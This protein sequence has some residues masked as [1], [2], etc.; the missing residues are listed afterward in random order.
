MDLNSLQLFVHV[1]QQG[2][3]SAASRKVRTPV[4]TISRRIS[5]L[6][7]Q[8]DQRLLERSTRSLDLTDAG[9][10]LYLFASRGFE[11]IA[12]GHVAM[13]ESQD[14]L[15]GTLRISIPPNVDAWEPLIDEF[16]QRYPK[17][18]LEVICTTRRIDFVEDG[19]DVVLRV[20]E[21]KHQLAVAR[22]LGS[23]RHVLVASPKFLQQHS[24]PKTPDE[25]TDLPL[26]AFVNRLG[27]DYWHLGDKKIAITPQFACNDYAPILAMVRKGNMISELPPTMVNKFIK[28]GE[29]VELL[30]EY[31]LPPFDLHLLY[32]SR[33][34][35][36]NIAKTYIDFCIEFCAKHSQDDSLFNLLDK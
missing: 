22:K 36:S 12:A 6:E 16:Y 24:A 30:A 1:V 18:Q 34:Y 9:K 27:D 11:E 26:A 25:L 20:G 2:S 13:Q 14:N 10:T 32:P 8:L 17:V 23:Y 31:P 33:K 4:S 3:F 19:I 21:L 7:S 28:S 29:L 15:S 35:L 5:E